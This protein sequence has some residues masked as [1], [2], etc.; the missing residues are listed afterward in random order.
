METPKDYDA[1]VEMK[2]IEIKVVFQ[3]YIKTEA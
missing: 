3:A 2:E 1:D